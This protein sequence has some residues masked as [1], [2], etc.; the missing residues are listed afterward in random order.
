VDTTGAGDAVAAGMLSHW[1]NTGQ[2]PDSLQE[3]LVWGVA[4][5]SI[6]ISGIG[7]RAIRS[8]T[9]IQLEE[10]VEEVMECLR[11]ES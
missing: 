1:L 11:R 3:S 5:A 6:T 10:R 8:A 7:L 9:R 4:C 2:D